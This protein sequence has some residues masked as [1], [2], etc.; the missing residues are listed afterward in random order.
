MIRPSA[1]SGAGTL[2]VPERRRDGDHP[3]QAV[4][5]AGRVVEGDEPAQ[6]VSEK[7]ERT[8]RVVPIHD[9]EEAGK[10]FQVLFPA[11]DIRPLSGGSAVPAQIERLHRQLAGHHVLDQLRI[12]SGVIAK[13]ME[14]DQD[15]FGGGGRTPRLT[16]ELQPARPGEP[17]LDVRDGAAHD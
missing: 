13:S 2:R 10:V 1:S 15:R 3:T 5:P 14:I 12:Q 16:E 8:A 7:K 11:L 4:G 9:R 6:A 17:A